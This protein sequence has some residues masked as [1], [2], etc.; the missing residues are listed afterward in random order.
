ML[1]TP[2]GTLGTLDDF[3]WRWVINFGAPGPDRGEGGEYRI[4]PA[5]YDRPL[6]EGG[7][8]V[9]RSRT[10]RVAVLGRKSMENNDPRCRSPGY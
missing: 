4:L 10:T 6:P 7:Y 2:P 8:F 5:G 1:E 9:T 3:W